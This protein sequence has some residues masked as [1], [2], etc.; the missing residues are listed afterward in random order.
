MI[1]VAPAQARIP[2][3]T[4]GARP[5]RP[6][7]VRRSRPCTLD[8]IVHQITTPALI[9]DPDNDFA[10]KGEPMRLHQALTSPN[11]IISL[12]EPEGLGE[13]CSYGGR[14]TLHQHMFDWLDRTLSLA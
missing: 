2:L 3:T 5:A 13:H 7:Y 12:A 6:D 1:V 11:T 14:A 4:A 8:G 9:F 10:F